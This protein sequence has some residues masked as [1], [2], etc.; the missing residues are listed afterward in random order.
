VSARRPERLT[1]GAGRAARGGRLTGGAG[2]A[3]RGGRLTGGAQMAGRRGVGG[4]GPGPLDL[5]QTAR[6]GLG[7]FESGSFDLGWTVGIGWL[8]SV[9]SSG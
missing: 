4:K 5:R 1:G 3:A 7:L 2:R 8:A 9:F 6:I